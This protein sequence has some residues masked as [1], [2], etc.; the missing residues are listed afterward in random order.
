MAPD[1]ED[2]DGIGAAIGVASACL[3][4]A[5]VWACAWLPLRAAVG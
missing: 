4:S 3:L 1:A 2:G 5:P